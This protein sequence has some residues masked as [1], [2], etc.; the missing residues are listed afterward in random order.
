MAKVA[1]ASAKL[2]RSRPKSWLIT[3]TLVDVVQAIPDD[4]DAGGD[5]HGD[6]GQRGAGVDQPFEL[7]PLLALRGPNAQDPRGDRGQHRR[8]HDEQP[9]EGSTT[10]WISTAMPVS[11][12]GLVP[13]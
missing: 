12:T 13:K 10:R 2:D 3:R 7:L 11:F 1:P 4:R 6:D 8:R 9:D 5:R